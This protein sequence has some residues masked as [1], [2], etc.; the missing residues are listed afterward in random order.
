MTETRKVFS[1]TSQLFAHRKH[2]AQIRFGRRYAKLKEKVQTAWLVD[3]E[4]METEFKGTSKYNQA[5]ATTKHNRIQEMAVQ[6]AAE[7]MKTVFS[8]W[9]TEVDR[10]IADLGGY[11]QEDGNIVFPDASVAK[12]PKGL[13]VTDKLRL[14]L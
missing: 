5:L 14:T 10:I 12:N 2:G 13:W 6:Q 3:L 8:E 7:I 11:P 9:R 1:K 4:K